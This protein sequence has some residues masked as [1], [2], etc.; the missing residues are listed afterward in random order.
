MEMNFK[1]KIIREA[2]ILGCALTFFAAL[3]IF[4]NSDVNKRAENILKYRR[5]LETRNQTIALLSNS[6]ADF[7][8]AKPMEAVLT[9]LLPSKDQLI[10]FPRELER[11]GK[12]YAVQ[13]GFTFGTE[14]PSSATEPGNIRYTLSVTGL[15]QD[16]ADFVEAFEKHPYFTTLDSIDVKII[17]GGTYSLITSGTIFTK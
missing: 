7:E 4:L 3:I 15:Y 17:N 11:M 14:Q 6:N 8:R 5:E 10:N 2:I 16:V 12:E 13:T 1:K 9:N